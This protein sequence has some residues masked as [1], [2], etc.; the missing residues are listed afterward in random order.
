M[1]KRDGKKF[2]AT[3]LALVL[4]FGLVISMVATAFMML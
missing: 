3:I 2:A 1:K 4:V